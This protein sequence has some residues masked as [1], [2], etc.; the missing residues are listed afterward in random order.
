MPA[1][2]QGPVRADHP[3]Q[4]EQLR[5]HSRP[6]PKQVDSL[7]PVPVVVVASPVLQVSVPLV[8][9]AQHSLVLVAQHSLV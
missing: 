4:R 2:V 8:L 9:V 6:A 3:A 1:P 7:A 5:I